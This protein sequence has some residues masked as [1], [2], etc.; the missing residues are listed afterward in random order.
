MA[1][2]GFIGLGN[3]GG[4]IAKRIIDA[5]HDVTLWARNRKTLEA[6][7]GTGATLAESVI[8]LAERVEH[9]GVCVVDD[10]GVKQ[11]CDQL[12]SSMRP[13]GCILIHSTVNPQL[14]RQLARR[15][16]DNGLHLLDAPVSG[17]GSGAAQ[18]T[19]TVMVGGA[20]SALDTVRPILESYAGLIIH[21]GDVGCGQNAKLVNNT[22]MAAH[23]TI[24]HHALQ[25]AEALGIEKSA[26]T[27]LVKVSSGRS[28]GFD[29]YARQESPSAFQH[30]AKL[31]LKDVL[32][33][34]SA[35]QDQQADQ[36]NFLSIRELTLPFIQSIADLTTIN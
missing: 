34:E 28:F 4:P 35:V 21:L 14:C 1:K 23:V 10:A 26:L 13:G 20:E 31:L 7:V 29:V 19:L 18:G 24:A 27:E 15:A 33:L 6:F 30:G 8:G 36:Q 25:V 12:I 5:G 22:L 32:L 17:G 3:Q 9:V 16:V 2:V 11:I